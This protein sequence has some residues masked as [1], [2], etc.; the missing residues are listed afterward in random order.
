LRKED[1]LIFFQAKNASSLLE[2]II[3]SKKYM[4]PQ[5]LD[6]L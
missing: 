3:D 1:K 2:P 6:R 5:M 4:N